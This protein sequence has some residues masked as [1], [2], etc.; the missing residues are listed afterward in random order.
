MP[1]TATVAEFEA[2][3]FEVINAEG[4]SDTPGIQG[5]RAR[6]ARVR[7][8]QRLRNAKVRNCV[9]ASLAIPHALEKLYSIPQVA[10]ADATCCCCLYFPTVTDENAAV[11]GGDDDH[12]NHD[13]TACGR[14]SGHSLCTH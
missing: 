3:L 6:L 7:A 8:Y 14:V 11:I 5:G 10:D 2:K 12:R 9:C 13:A 1:E 4:T